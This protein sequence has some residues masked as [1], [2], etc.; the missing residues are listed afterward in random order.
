MLTEFLGF[1]YRRAAFEALTPTTQLYLGQ[2]DRARRPGPS[3]PTSWKIPH[4]VKEHMHVRQTFPSGSPVT[5]PG[6]SGFH[7]PRCV[8]SSGP[9]PNRV[10]A[11]ANR[12]VPRWRVERPPPVAHGSSK[13][14]QTT[15]S[16]W[17]ADTSPELSQPHPH[18]SRGIRPGPPTIPRGFALG[19][20]QM[21]RQGLIVED[22]TEQCLHRFLSPAL[23]SAHNSPGA[24]AF[25]ISCCRRNGGVIPAG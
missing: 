9:R 4:L 8:P 3:L 2:R 22:R 15:R 14:P 5:R 21:T 7:I 12:S 23:R 17:L 1:K 11:M 18:R 24:A 16:L 19:I 13:A 10:P 25:P 20:A 6:R